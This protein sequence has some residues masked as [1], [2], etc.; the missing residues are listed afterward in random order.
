[1]SNLSLP[2][3]QQQLRQ[4]TCIGNEPKAISF[5][6]AEVQAALLLLASH[7]DY[8]LFGICA[9]TLTQGAEALQ[10]Y[11]QALGYEEIPT[12]DPTAAPEGAIYIKFNPRTGKCHVDRYVGNHRGVLV[13]CQSAYDGDINETF[14]HLPLDLFQVELKTASQQA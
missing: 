8:Q 5:N 14:G 9:D 13:S 7:S 10:T 12:V 4:F 2:F 6:A 3:A 1:M 11:L